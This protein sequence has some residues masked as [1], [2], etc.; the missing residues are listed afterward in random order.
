MKIDRGKYALGTLRVYP[1][2]RG[3]IWGCFGDGAGAA[4]IPGW[5][6]LTMASKLKWWISLRAAEVTFR[7][8]RFWRFCLG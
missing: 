3:C 7:I 1:G 6:W 2:R 5:L 8:G 4:K